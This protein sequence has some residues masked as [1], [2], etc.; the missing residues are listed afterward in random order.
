ME[1]VSGL[2]TWQTGTGSIAHGSNGI[3]PVVHV[4]TVPSI[5]RSSI[6]VSR[7]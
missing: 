1:V 4:T 2:L 5:A 3:F 7:Q 6:S